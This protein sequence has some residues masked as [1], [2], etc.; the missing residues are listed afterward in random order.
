MSLNSVFPW[1]KTPEQR[2]L[3]R[4]TRN[5][6][7]NYFNRLK[8]SDHVA[9]K[10]CVWLLPWS[11]HNYPGIGRGIVQLLGG[12]TNKPAIDRW[13][14]RTGTAPRWAL[15]ELA[16]EIERRCLA[17][18]EIVAALRVHASRPRKPNGL[19]IID[20]ETGLRKHQSHRAG[21]LAGERKPPKPA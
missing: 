7:R 19:N 9:R 5:L 3:R 18:L 10:A 17:G 4:Q 15:R 12:R 16:D 8:P 11:M 2:E 1:Q 21:G 14:Y 20:P 6:R 13:Q